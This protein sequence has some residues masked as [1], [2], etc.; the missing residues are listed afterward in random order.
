MIAHLQKSDFCAFRKVLATHHAIISVIAELSKYIA[1]LITF[2]AALNIF[3]AIS[4][5]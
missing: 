5:M 4:V 2:I 3:I 1:V